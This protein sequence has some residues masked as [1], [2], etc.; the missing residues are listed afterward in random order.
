[1]LGQAQK[2]DAYN[3]NRKK[4]KKIGKHVILLKISTYAH[5]SSEVFVQLVLEDLYLFMWYVW[6]HNCLGILKGYFKLSEINDCT[7]FLLL[8]D[9]DKKDK[10]QNNRRF[11]STSKGWAVQ[12]S[13]GKDKKLHFTKEK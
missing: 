7:K 8:K 2:W 4:K 3:R 10:I 11:R 13:E 5:S 6:H 12:F 9:I 1:M